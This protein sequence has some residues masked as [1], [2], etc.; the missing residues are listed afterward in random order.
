MP[1]WFETLVLAL[2]GYGLGFGVGWVVFAGAIALK[3]GTDDD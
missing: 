1:I 3:E 2:L